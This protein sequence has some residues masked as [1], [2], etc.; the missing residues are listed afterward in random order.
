MSQSLSCIYVHIIF[1]TKNRQPLILPEII[2]DLHSYIVGIARAYD[3][4]IH[5]IGGI[6]D[7]VHIL[8]TLSRTI[9]LSKLVEEI[10]KQS[11]RWIKTQGE[12]Y[13][14][15]AWQN[16]FGAFSIGQSAFENL[17]KYILTQKDHHKKI[18]FQDEFRAFL[19]KYQTSY[20][21]KYVW[22]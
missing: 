17:R 18:S 10:K 19:K 16:G 22:G 2:Q 8:L 9:S 11:S 3:S 21:E 15:F 5:V 12:K 6:E 4:P 20:D 1:S 7:H 14:D 13:R